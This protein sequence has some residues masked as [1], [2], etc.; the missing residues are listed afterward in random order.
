MGQRPKAPGFASLLALLAALHVGTS[1]EAASVSRQCRRACRDGLAACVGAGGH[2]RA[3]RKS[4][5][6]RCKIE[7]VA[8]CQGQADGAGRADGLN[9][10]RGTKSTTT[11]TTTTTRP[12]TTTTTATTSAT[13]TTLAGAGARASGLHYAANH[14]FPSSGGYAP[15][16]AGFNLADLS[17]VS[18]LNA[19]PSGVKG[20][21]WLGLCNG[22]D[23]TFINAVKPFIGNPKL[24]GFY[25]VDEPDPTG[26]WNPLCPAVNLLAESDWI[27]ANVPGA[28]TF[29]VLMNFG[30][31]KSP[32]YANT[33]NPGNS[34]IDLYGLDPYPC[35]SELGGCD[36]G[37]ITVAVAAAEAAG[38][39]VGSIV[40]VYQ[41]FGGGSWSDDGGGYYLLPTPSEEQQI[42]ATWAA[43][44]PTP[45]FDYSY[46]WGTQ[47]SD[48]ALESSTDLQA[49]FAAHNQ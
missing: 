22:A 29:I 2:P 7:G 38:I 40:P 47:N 23:A 37:R 15:A 26:Q 36:Y 42:L 18:T 35:R 25:L 27:H 19:L 13:T 28:K 3:C 16:Q 20:L 43:L 49:V 8:A 34:H 6:G 48:Q 21:V 5:L 30:S 1:A 9:H 44:V 41:A 39:P 11:T 12:P 45:V 33:Y 4:V 17:G 24:F 14:N 10:G 31:T 32:T 46:S